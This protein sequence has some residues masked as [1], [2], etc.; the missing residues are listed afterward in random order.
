M[1]SGWVDIQGTVKHKLVT[2]L[3]AEEQLGTTEEVHSGFFFPVVVG[4]LGT[5]EKVTLYLP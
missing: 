1:K 3:F 4:T 2:R 5:G